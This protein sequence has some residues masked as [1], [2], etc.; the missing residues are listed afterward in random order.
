MSTAN[1]R[2]LYNQ[3]LIGDPVIT[4]GSSRRVEFGN[5][6]ADWNLS[7]AEYAKGSAL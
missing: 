1:A 2:W 5:G 6:Y 7:Y 4:T 3:V